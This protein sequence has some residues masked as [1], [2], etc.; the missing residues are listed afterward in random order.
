MGSVCDN[1]RQSKRN[2]LNEEEVQPLQ[3]VMLGMRSLCFAGI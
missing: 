1:E 2:V 3:V